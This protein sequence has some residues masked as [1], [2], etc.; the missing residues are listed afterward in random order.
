ME[1]VTL[2]LVSASLL[3]LVS[4]LT[5]AGSATWSAS[6]STVDWNTAG[7]WIPNTVPNGP[8]DVA[9]FGTSIRR[10][11][12][13]SQETEINS[14]VFNPGARPFT[15]ANDPSHEVTISGAGVIN[16]SGVMQSIVAKSGLASP[17]QRVDFPA[18]PC[19]TFTNSAVAGS[20][21]TY[22]ANSGQ[23]T[24]G[25]GGNFTFYDSASADH[26][27]FN[28]H[29]SSDEAYAALIEFGNLS[30]GA[31]ATINLFDTGE[32]ELS[33]SSPDLP[34]LGNATVTNAG[35]FVLL[36][37]TVTLGN[38]T[39]VNTR[40]L[41]P[42]L[43][44]LEVMDSSSTLGNATITNQG[45]T[46]LAG[47]GTTLFNFGGM[48]G[49]AV[50]INNGGDA[51]GRLGGSITFGLIG[52]SVPDAQEA[53]LIA[54]PGI[55]GGSGGLIA[56]AKDS[57]GGTARCEV[58][59]NG[60]LDI[61]SHGTPGMT[62]GSVEG[63]G[64]VFLGALNL[65]LGSNNLSTTF[66]GVIQDG[67]SSGG[68]GGSLS[69]IGTGGLTLASANTYTGGTVIN[70][71]TLLVNNAAGSGLGTGPVQVTSGILGGTGKI[72]AKVTVGIGNGAG[73][74]VG[75]GKDP[76]TPG[77]LTIGKSL[78]LNADATYRV[79]LNS[80]VPSADAIVAKGVRVTQAQMVLSDR[81]TAALAPGTAFTLISNT[82]A[83]PISGTFVNLPD[84]GAITVGSNTFQANYKGGDGNDLTLTVV[85]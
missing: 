54:N 84:G 21:V 70:G 42:R 80:S 75:P 10:T 47:E 76:Y 34:T 73:A 45:A 36:V 61:S 77:T 44:S 14:I 71:G 78:T 15:I 3:A 49:Q 67:G 25:I 85:P 62:T 37:G 48:A 53:T 79:T 1:R 35:G 51:A 69:K 33:A 56:F 74:V 50:I 2:T 22:T 82:S 60:T 31:N 19:F 16:N 55:N 8:S 66:S 24:F 57:S 7:N 63:D 26:A 40:E 43:E 32:L 64:L 52:G 39:I 13:F 30:T 29:G 38:A 28:I 65:T 4:Q 83:N 11:V 9:S 72:S 68:T 59:G 18:F 5:F 58:F 41:S 81:G 23:D 12:S 20:N 6:P 17:G 27:V 46:A